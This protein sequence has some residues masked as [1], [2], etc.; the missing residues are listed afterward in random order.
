MAP[1]AMMPSGLG[2][3][4]HDAEE[5]LARTHTPSLVIGGELDRLLPP[6]LSRRIADALPDAELHVLEGAGH[7]L[8]LERPDEV[9]ALLDAFAAR[10]P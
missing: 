1:A 10:L 7:Q 3:V 9:A 4:S 6:A 5:A 8:M 2:L